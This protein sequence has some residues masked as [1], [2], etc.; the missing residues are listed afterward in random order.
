MSVCVITGAS[1][2]MGYEFVKEIDNYYNFDS[3][4]VIARRIER[5]KDLQKLTKSL[6]IPLKL[7]LTKEESLNEYKKYLSDNNHD[8]KMLINCAGF[9]IFDEFIKTPYE[10]N[11]KMVNL[12][13]NALQAMTYLTI[14]YMKESS[15][16]LNLASMSSI[17]PV[18][19][20][21]LYAATKA[22]VLSFSRGLNIELKKR[23]IKVIA[24]TPYWV[25]TEFFEVAN[26]ENIIKNF[27][28]LYTSEYIVK[29]VF[30]KITKKKV[31]DVLCP[32]KYARMQYRLVKLLPHNLVMKIWLKKQKL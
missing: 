11:M 5:L 28:I 16:I 25:K 6:I 15:I 14:P 12:N 29:Y 22:F 3:I 26:K 1:S 30:K 21:N 8:V 20:I 17:Q 10:T 2:G 18:P 31:K 19:Y 24:I 4:I 7:D 13:C 9:G 23:K 27:D 32:G